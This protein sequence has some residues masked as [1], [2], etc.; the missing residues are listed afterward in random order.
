MRVV[1]TL[2]L[3]ILLCLLPAAALAADDPRLVRAVPIKTGNELLCRL[4]TAGLPGAKQ[5][6]S[7]QSGLVSAVE[8]NLVLVDDKDNVL[9]GNTMSLRLAFDL[10]DE[11]FSARADGTERRLHS[12]ADLQNYLAE[13]PELPVAPASRLKPDGRYQIKV[14][15]VLHAIAPDEQKRVEDVIAGRKRPVREGLDQQ[16]ASVSLG[17]LIKLFYKGS[18]DS[19]GGLELASAWFTGKELTGE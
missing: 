6:Q 5:L 15:M 2:T 7:M 16:E 1:R 4:Q 19:G 10:W 9:A 13:M 12:L 14:R 8:L 11:V 18:Q 17:R 3:G